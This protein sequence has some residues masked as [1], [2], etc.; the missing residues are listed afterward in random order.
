MQ[1][2]NIAYFNLFLLLIISVKGVG[3]FAPPP[4]NEGSTAIHADS[5]VIKKWANEI[6]V[7][8]GFLNVT[9]TS[10]GKA[11]H[12][13]PVNATGEADDRVVSLGDDGTATYVPET[14]LANGE[15]FDFAIYEN[16]FSDDFLELAFVEVSSDGEHFVRFPAVSLTQTET[17]V[18]SFET[19]DPQKVHNLAGKYRVYYGTP[20]D[21]SDLADSAALD[22]NHITHIRIRDVVGTLDESFA[23]Y[24]SEGNMVNDPWPTEFPSGGFDLDAVAVLNDV[25]SI[26]AVAQNKTQPAVYPNP[27]TNRLTVEARDYPCSVSLLTLQGQRLK[28]LAMDDVRLTLDMSDLTPGAYLLKVTGEKINF[29]KRIIKR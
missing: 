15:G 10:L 7:Q 2:V 22:L 25:N 18:G 1:K 21:L 6:E 8:R 13:E 3:Q 12:G 9:D 24:D 11:S 17:Q 28:K 16:S 26:N 5:S 14:P 29:V 27:V 20:F 4:G 23:T 19:I